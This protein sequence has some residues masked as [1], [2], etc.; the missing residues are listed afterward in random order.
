MDPIYF[1]KFS[2]RLGAKQNYKLVVKDRSRFPEAY[3][4]FRYIYQAD[5]KKK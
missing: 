5:K 2:L 3:H 4:T 1:F